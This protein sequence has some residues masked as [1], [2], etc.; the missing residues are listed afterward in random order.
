MEILNIE[1]TQ[2]VINATVVVESPAVVVETI[3][4]GPPGPAGGIEEAP[5]DTETYAR[6]DGA[7]HPLDLFTRRET[8][9]HT[10]AAP[11]Y[12]GSVDSG[13]FDTF[14]DIDA[15]W[16]VNELFDK[17]VRLEHR[18]TGEFRF[19]IILS[20]TTTVVT[21]DDTLSIELTSEW[22]YTVLDTLVITNTRAIVAL[23]VSSNS[24]GVILPS[25][26]EENEREPIYIYIEHNGG[27]QSAAI[28]CRGIERQLGAKNGELFYKGEG[29]SLA[30]H[31][32]GVNHW[33]VLG[34]EGIGRY[35]ESY[36]N[37]D[38]PVTT[39]SYASIGLYPNITVDGESRFQDWLR[40]GEIWYR[41]ASLITKRSVVRAR[42]TIRKTGGVGEFFLAL[43]KR[44]GI[45]GVVTNLTARTA[46]TRFGSGTGV[47]DIA[48]D[49]PVEL[50]FMDE[51][52]PIAYNSGG[53]FSI[54]SGSSFSVREL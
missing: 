29:V 17:V 18:I 47:A 10:A 11:L 15:T 13:S 5:V 45:T 37:S 54:L 31:R 27:T 16:S 36:W 20:N 1:V 23:D 46:A 28:V 49:V 38:E 12:T 41:Y 35:I 51:V 40:G 43:A 25:V 9:N 33:D 53:S 52:I 6:R 32:W 22:D 7:W 34:T 19:A 4:Q 3:Q 30:P 14:T 50:S 39:G 2:E 42:I 26:T 21:L 24:L 8:V 44:D 48:L